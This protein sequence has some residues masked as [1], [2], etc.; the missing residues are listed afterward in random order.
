MKVSLT[1][2]T[3]NDAKVLFDMQVEAFIKVPGLRNKS[4]K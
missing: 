4:C 1:K 3:N 2:A